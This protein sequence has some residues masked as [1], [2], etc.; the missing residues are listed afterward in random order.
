[1]K[2]VNSATKVGSGGGDAG[3]LQ[4]SQFLQRWAWPG[5]QWILPALQTGKYRQAKLNVKTMAREPHK[6][7]IAEQLLFTY[8]IH[9]VDQPAVRLLQDMI[10]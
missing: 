6:C 9:Q 5:W 2:R 1:M 7:V 10:M 4:Q 3:D 8:S